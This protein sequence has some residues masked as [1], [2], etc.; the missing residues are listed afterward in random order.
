MHNNTC[1]APRSSYRS[2]SSAVHV[3]RRAGVQPIGR[4]LCLRLRTDLWPTSH[5]QP[6]SAV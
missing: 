3:T 4:R 6:W 5:T 2:C 1:I